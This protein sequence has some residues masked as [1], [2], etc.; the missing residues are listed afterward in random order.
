MLS[1]FTSFDGPTISSVTVP[2][3]FTSSAFPF[4]TR[5]FCEVTGSNLLNT[6]SSE[7]TCDVA[8]ESTTQFPYELP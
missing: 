3:P 6:V 4:A 5:I 8:P 2:Y 7:V 1:I